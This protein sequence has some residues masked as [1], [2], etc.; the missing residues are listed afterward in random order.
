MQYEA[1]KLLNYIISITSVHI[2]VFNILTIIK[3][4]EFLPY[5]II[6]LDIFVNTLL[7]IVIMFTKYLV[8]TF[9]IKTMRVQRENEFLI[10]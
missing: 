7:C 10:F 4:C 2:K 9:M 8:L 6:D 5:E 3:I 1:F